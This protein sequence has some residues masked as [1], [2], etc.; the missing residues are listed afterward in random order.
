MK[1]E[2]ESF[3]AQTFVTVLSVLLAL[4]FGWVFLWLIRD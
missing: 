4:V 1:R 3:G 2:Q